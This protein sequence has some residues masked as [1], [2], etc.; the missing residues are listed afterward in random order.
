[1]GKLPA[2]LESKLAERSAN[3]SL[4]SLPEEADRVDFSSNDYLGL[5]RERAIGK[6]T[7]DLL[8]LDGEWRR[9]ASGSRLLSGN[10]ALYPKLES[11]L[12]KHHNSEAALVFN[13]GY[14]ANVGFFSSVPQRG[15]MVLYDELI[16]A[17][18]RDG[19]KMGNAKSYKFAHNDLEDLRTKVEK[20]LRALCLPTGRQSRSNDSEIYIVTESVFS[21]D[22]DSPDLKPMVQICRD[23]G[24][25]L[26]I[27][28][29]HATGIYG[30]GRDLVCKMGLKDEIFAR[31]ITF[32]KAMGGHGAAILGSE[33]LKTY[34]INFARSLIYTTALSPHSVAGI[35]ASYHFLES[36]GKDH[37]IGLLNNIEHF[38][39]QIRELGLE[40][41]FIESNSAIHC[42]IVPGNQ[43]VKSL[44]GH[45]QQAGYNVKPILSPTVKGGEERLRF[46]LHAFNTREEITSILKEVKNYLN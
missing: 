16:H 21:M 18:I 6:K 12:A 9:G 13:S 42:L 10:H 37:I 36:N 4:R 41:N 28:E 7:K 2:K 30:D 1:M 11:F 35:L 8:L 33:D 45:L 17:S 23:K 46:C 39:A 32:G 26:I 24:C 31:I 5:A 43:Q 34:L 29:A 27:D 20:S 3:Q 25:H 14:D 38:N 44:A 40:K 22:G 15:D 19:I